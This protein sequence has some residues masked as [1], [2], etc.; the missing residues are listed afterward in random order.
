MVTIRGMV[1]ADVDGALALA[2][3]TPEAPRWSRDDYQA[4]INP[5]AVPL[6]TGLIAEQDGALAG[7][8]IVKL[9][10]GIAELESIAVMESFRSRGLGRALVEAALACVREHG[11]TRFELEVRASNAAAIALYKG[12]GFV[13]EGRRARYYAAPVEDALLMAIDWSAE[14]E[15]RC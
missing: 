9:V 11:A 4:C 13:T 7:F 2:L 3:K 14:P 15:N 8:V 6:R 1:A 12:T 10:A 5:D